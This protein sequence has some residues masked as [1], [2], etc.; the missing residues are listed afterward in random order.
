MAMASVFMLGCQ[1]TQPQ[2]GETTFQPAIDNAMM[3]YQ[4]GDLQLAEGLWRRLLQRDPSLFMAWCHLGH[5]GFRQ[6]DYDTALN[7]Y[8]KCLRQQPQQAEIWHNMAVIKLRQA[9]ELLIQGSAYLPA[10]DS[11]SHDHK[12]NYQRLLNALM[13]LQRV[14]QAED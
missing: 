14:S 10:E 9:S 1:T 13:A 8:Q 3:A 4:Q 11:A 2:L 6:H 5:I 7:A 12:H